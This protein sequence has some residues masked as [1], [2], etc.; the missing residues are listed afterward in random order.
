MRTPQD[1]VLKSF[2]GKDGSGQA[3]Q[4]ETWRIHIRHC[5]EEYRPG[6]LRPC[7]GGE[8]EPSL[9]AATAQMRESTR[10]GRG[11]PV[12]VCSSLVPR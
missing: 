5:S 7:F 2:K 6:R 8:L 1:A 3:G 4:R 12:I 9:A 10:P 11:T